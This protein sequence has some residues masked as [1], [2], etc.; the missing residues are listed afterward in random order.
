MHGK[1][2]KI[3]DVH[4]LAEHSVHYTGFHKTYIFSVSLNFGQLQWIHDKSVEKRDNYR[5]K[6]IYILK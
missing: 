5:W 2:I 4:R 3:I 6:L 1:C